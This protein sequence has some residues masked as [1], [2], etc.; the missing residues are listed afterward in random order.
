MTVDEKV[1]YKQNAENTNWTIAE[2]QAWVNSSVF[3]LSKAVQAF[4]IERFKHNVNKACKG[5]QYVLD[6]MFPN[7]ETELT[8]SIDINAL[9]PMLKEKIREKANEIAAAAKSKAVP[10]V[11]AAQTDQREQQT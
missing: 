11:A 9:N 1:T 7:I 2:R 10:F 5:F 3:G 8:K 6:T 4:G